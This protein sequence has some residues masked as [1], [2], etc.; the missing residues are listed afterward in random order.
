[1]A[2]PQIR[3]SIFPS[4]PEAHLFEVRCT[5]DNPDPWGQA[6]SLP[7]WIPGSYLIREFA[8][9]VVRIRAHS[10]HKLLRMVKLDKNTW[11]VEPFDGPVTVTMEVYAWDLSVRG[12]HLD[13]TH[14]FFN[15]PSVFLKVGDREH[16][17]VEVEI[18]PPKGAKYRNWG[19]ATAMRRKGARPYLFGTFEAANYDELIDHPVEMGTF[20]LATFK[21]AGV[22]H[23][24]AITGRHRTDMRRLTK[25]LKTLCETQIAFF[26]MPA[27]MDRYV[28]LVTAV[29]EGY[30]GLEHRASTALICSR[31]DLPHEGMDK[32]TSGYRTFLGL[33]SHE[34]FH[35]WNVKRIKPAAFTPYDLERENYTTLLWA[36]EGFTSYYDDLL[37]VRAGL[38]PRNTYLDTLGRNI[39]TLL[40]TS[41]RKK[42][43]VAES[44][45]DAWIKYYRSDEN[46]PNAGVSY[47]GKGS[48]V[49]LGLDLLIRDQTGGRKSLDDVMRALW[50]RYGMKG[51]GVPEDGIEKTAEQVTGL[52]LKRFF[53]Q[54]VRSTTDL[55]LQKLLA[56]V[57]VDMAL[58]T[59]RSGVDRRERKP[60]RAETAAGRGVALGIRTGTEGGNVRITHVLDGGA[61]QKAG[62]ASGDLVI[63]MDGLRVTPDQFESHVSRYRAGETIVLHTFRRDE[64][65]VV[66]V[67]LAAT[68][69]DA[70]SLT[71]NEDK[72]GARARKR[73]LGAD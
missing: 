68:K 59:P 29:G 70:W 19:V 27:P 24:I 60:T 28:F 4:N 43:T 56:T 15:G 8:K 67:T 50:K 3:Y 35:T 26:G 69:P 38:M 23:D 51:I 73:W 32:P 10:G 31:N 42:Q 61:A 53:D 64:L 17:P 62:L 2:N 54:A 52:K 58:R 46:T 5:V 41:G 66:N 45:F 40:R 49:A 20:E 63:A 16:E 12:A 14:G 44:S 6:F 18:L 57:G 11:Q 39:T 7:T 9:H 65:N 71:V 47:Y 37:L 33:A 21:A 25:D 13:T 1:M 22:Q 36:F 48:L 55:P 34:Y 30:G 72:E